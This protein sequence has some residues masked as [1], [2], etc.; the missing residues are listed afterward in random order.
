MAHRAGVEKTEPQAE[1]KTSSEATRSPGR[2]G[3]GRPPSIP[4]LGSRSQF[5][6]VGPDSGW[7]GTVVE[8]ILP[9]PSSKLNSWDGNTQRLSTGHGEVLG[10]VK[11]APAPI[12]FHVRTSG[13]INILKFQSGVGH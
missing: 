4:G 1:H 10:C 2:A 3:V 9:E 5:K 12:N 6:G 11:P 13:Q 7:S 8:R